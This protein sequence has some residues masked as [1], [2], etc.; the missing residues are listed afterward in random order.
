MKYISIIAATLVAI[1][2]TGVAHAQ[3]VLYNNLGATDAT[4]HPSSDGGSHDLPQN[5]G[6]QAGQLFTDT[7]ASSISQVEAYFKTDNGEATSNATGLLIQ[8]FNFSGTGVGTMVGQQTLTSYSE[9]DTGTGSN[10]Q[11]DIT[12]STNISGLTNGNQYLLTMQV[13]SPDW[14][15]LEN[16]SSGTPGTYVR[17]YSSFGYSGSSGYSSSWTELS[18][19]TYKYTSGNSLM[20]ITGNQPV[21]EPGTIAL[22]FGIGLVSLLKIRRN[23]S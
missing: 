12:A 6:V 4:G 2:L 10:I 21:P 16:D 15:Y 14:M 11:Y 20:E 23:L 8:V 9:K 18:Q 1:G 7:T 17:N 22:A 19:T 3:V 13:Q 5:Y